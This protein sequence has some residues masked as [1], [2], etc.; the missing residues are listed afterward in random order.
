MR[1]Y[2]PIKVRCKECDE[3]KDETTVE[4][5]DIE[6]DFQGRDILTFK[7]PDCGTKQRSL[8]LG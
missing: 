5:L 7:C 3:W 8:R 2:R 6:E 4:T 1:R